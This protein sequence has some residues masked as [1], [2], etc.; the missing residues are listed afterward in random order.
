MS[1]QPSD[2]QKKAFKFIEDKKLFDEWL[3]SNDKVIAFAKRRGF[4]K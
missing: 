2:K 4:K 3:N 1:R